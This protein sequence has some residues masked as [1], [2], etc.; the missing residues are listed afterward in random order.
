M[1]CPTLSCLAFSTALAETEIL[2]SPIAN[3]SGALNLSFLGAGSF[4]FSSG[5]VSLTDAVTG[6]DLWRFAWEY[7]LRGSVPWNLA[8]GTAALSPYTSLF[9]SRSYRLKINTRISSNNDPEHVTIGL[10]GLKAVAVPEPSS[11]LSLFVGSA[12]VAWRTARRR[13]RRH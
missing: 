4:F 9:A 11:L 5:F 6:E 1:G 12:F 10:T 2:F 13:D 3:T 7:P 8:L